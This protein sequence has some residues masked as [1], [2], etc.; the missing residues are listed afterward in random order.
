ML[1]FKTVRSCGKLDYVY[2][3]VYSNL[4]GDDEKSWEKNSLL[5][6]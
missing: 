2:T 5:K 1:T 6:R 4:F 3:S